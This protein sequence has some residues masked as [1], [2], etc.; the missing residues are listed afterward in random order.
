MFM[1]LD[2]FIGG[3]DGLVLVGLGLFALEVFLPTKGFLG[4]C[5]LLFFMCG[6]YLMAHHPDPEQRLGFGAMIALNVGVLA[7]FSGVFYVM[8]RGYFRPDALRPDLVGQTGRIVN[9]GDGHGR[10][11]I[12]GV[13]WNAAS[14]TVFTPGDTA[15]VTRLQGLILYLE[16]GE[17]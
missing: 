1:T 2:A 10:V 4:V 13:T 7:V 6:T 3:P 5:G 11:D 16:K 14:D 15:R 9:W 8:V 17:T 12:D